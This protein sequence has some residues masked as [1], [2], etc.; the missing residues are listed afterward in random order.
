MN[1]YKHPEKPNQEL[2]IWGSGGIDEIPIKLGHVIE[3]TRNER[4]SSNR[5]E[6]IVLFFDHNDRNQ[7]ECEA[8][9]KKW[10][11]EDNELEVATELRL[12]QWTD[13]T[14]ELRGSSAENHRL[15][16]LPIALPPDSKGN[17]EVFLMDSIRGQSGHDNQLVGKAREFIRDLPDKPYLDKTRYRP[18]AC[19]GSILSVISPDWV[20]SK[21]NNRLTRVQ[22]EEIESVAAVYEKLSAL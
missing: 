18:K 22:W 15:S 16:I 20:I 6:C 10:T 4:I 14:V 1:W 8:L 19:L 13:A 12:G 9:V 17:L 2:A 5:F 21:L 7:D 3:R 11:T